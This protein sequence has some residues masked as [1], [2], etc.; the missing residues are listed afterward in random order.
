HNSR[1][2]NAA[3]QKNSPKMRQKA[4]GTAS[5]HSGRRASPVSDA[6]RSSK[7]PINSSRAANEQVKEFSRIAFEKSLASFMSTPSLV[8]PDTD[9]EQP[10]ATALPGV[11]TLTHGKGKY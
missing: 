2:K 3:P 9:L 6:D 11:Q 4:N 7:K 1:A 10:R 5:N 8:F